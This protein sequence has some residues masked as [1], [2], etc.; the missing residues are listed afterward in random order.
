MASMEIHEGRV[1]LHR[2]SGPAVAA[3]TS[4]MLGL[5]ALALVNIGT[6]ASEPFKSL[7]H[8]VGKLWIPGAQGIGPYSGKETVMLVVWL[9][10]WAVL[11]RLL[12]NH[13]ASLLRWGVV[14]LTG[15][16][17]ATTL[18]W[19]PIIHLILHG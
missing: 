1:T 15:I 2:P 5:L 17:L 6:E 11:H 19:P 13:E 14:F 10:S 18:M 12:R 8:N 16:G 3:F 9:V 7:I 4:A